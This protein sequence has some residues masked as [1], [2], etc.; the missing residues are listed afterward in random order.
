MNVNMNIHKSTAKQ[1]NVTTDSIRTQIKSTFEL[2]ELEALFE[3]LHERLNEHVNEQINDHS[4]SM[5][6]PVATSSS[7]F[8]SKAWLLNW[9]KVIDSPVSLAVFYHHKEHHNNEPVGFALL[10]KQ[11]A[12]YGDTYYLNQTGNAQN[13][14]MWIE[15][16]DVVCPQAYKALCRASLLLALRKTPHFHRAVMSMS[17]TNDWPSAGLF[18]WLN[19][20]TPVSYVNLESVHAQQQGYE[21]TLSKNTKSAVKRAAKYIEN[22]H[23]N[24]SMQVSTQNLSEL[25]INDIAP[26]HIQQWG[27]TEH[28]SGFSNPV[29]AEFLQ[30]LCTQSSE[31]CHCE[32]L[33][34]KAGDLVLGHL[35][36][37]ISHNEVYFYLSAINYADSDNKYKPGML[38]HTLAI[39]HYSKL[40]M[41]KYDFLAG[42]ARY[43]ESLSTHTYP[44]YTVHLA[45][46]TWMHRLLFRLNDLINTLKK[47]ST[48]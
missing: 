28:G 19:E 10:G 47:P 43:K 7:L 29:F 35:F 37:I 11:S 23:G 38:I 48:S 36:N 20:Q 21:S 16:N 39:E 2:T 24:I 30:R 13:D 17:T 3:R 44:M 6:A 32:V 15:Q 26:L 31:V 12:W 25:L 27:A 40:N 14:Q 33:S 22:A 41:S 9:L 45:K 4:D 1:N 18:T 5:P 42:Q 8:L 34:F 46:N